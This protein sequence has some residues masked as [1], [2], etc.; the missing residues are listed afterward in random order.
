MKRANINIIGIVQG[1][2]FRHEVK[3][4]ANR[5]GITG[6]IKNEN[7]G[8]LSMVVEG[9]EEKLEHLIDWCKSGP[10]FARVKD[11]EVKFDEATGEFKNFEI[12][13]A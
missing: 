10:S 6:W 1:V 7:N 9:E 8:S 2:N 3:N 11:V 5:L 4:H 13:Y 12:R